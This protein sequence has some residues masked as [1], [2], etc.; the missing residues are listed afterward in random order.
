MLPPTP[1]QLHLVSIRF[2]RKISCVTSFTISNRL[3][4]YYFG[5]DFVNTSSLSI[6]GAQNFFSTYVKDLKYLLF[7]SN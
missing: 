2:R 6:T 3:K 4:K 5:L 7:A 1:T